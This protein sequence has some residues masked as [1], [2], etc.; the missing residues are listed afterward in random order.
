MAN[1]VSKKFWQASNG[2]ALGTALA[3]RPELK[4]LNDS[5]LKEI[6][7]L[8]PPLDGCQVL[9]L[10]AGTGRFT[11]ELA[12]RAQSLTALDISTEALQQNRLKHAQFNNITYQSIDA[13]E[14]H[15]ET[16]PFDFI[17]INWLFMYLDDDD[18]Q[19]LLQNLQHALKPGG[20]IFIR[21]SCEYAY[22]GK[23]WLR[24]F[25]HSGWQTIKPGKQQSIYRLQKFR[26]PFWKNALWMTF[27]SARVQNYRSVTSYQALFSQ[28][29]EV[30]DS[31]YLV[32]YELAYRHQNQRYWMLR[33]SAASVGDGIEAAPRSWSFGGEVWRSFDSHIH[34]SIPFY[35]QLHEVIIRLCEQLLTDGGAVYELGCST[36]SLCR[37][38]KQRLPS[39]DVI[40][41]DIE[42]NMIQAA[43]AAGGAV[44]YHCADIL[45]HPMKSCSVAILSY[46]LQF[47]APERR[48]ELLKK[49]QTQLKSGGAII[50][51]EKVKRRDTQL[52][53]LL[54]RAHGQYKLDQGFSKEEINAKSASLAGV[55]TP[56]YEDENIELLQ[57]AGLTRVS[58][59][60]NNLTFSAWIAFKD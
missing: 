2:E 42:P 39:A 9:E 41:V 10:G 49:I 22:N 37:Q 50:L 31:G 54:Q 40:G 38:L 55:M 12:R 15:N 29:F 20:Q 58:T 4:T 51:A 57:Q 5:E 14:Y 34:R 47:V 26:G 60:F 11:G 59:I 35:P 7:A 28:N 17:F 43:E 13:L 19:A 30:I 16:Q 32:T 56:L 24:N 33:K 53:Q 21:E 6:F 8:L 52:E 44:Q 27:N 3:S 45:E 25:L 1:R 18:S 36:G 46:T 48:L 23:S